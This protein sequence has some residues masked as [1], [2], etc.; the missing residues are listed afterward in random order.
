MLDPLAPASVRAERE[1]VPE[2][3]PDGFG[4]ERVEVSKYG[5]AGTWS[6]CGS[7]APPTTEWCGETATRR[8][9][10]RFGP[11]P[12]GSRRRFPHATLSGHETY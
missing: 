6:W 1:R 9:T 7:S 4:I 11:R 2:A 10:V 8:T 5:E 3:L 12:F